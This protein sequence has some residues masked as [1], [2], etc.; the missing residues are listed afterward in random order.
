M[1]NES[2]FNLDEINKINSNGF[3]AL[4]VAIVNGYW[5]SVEILIKAGAV[6]NINGTDL[7]MTCLSKYYVNT[8]KL[9]VENG[10]SVAD[11]KLADLSSCMTA[12]TWLIDHSKYSYD[13]ETAIVEQLQ[14]VVKSKISTVD[15]VNIET[16]S[17]IFTYDTDKS[18]EIIKLLI[19]ENKIDIKKVFKSNEV[20]TTAL[21]TAAEKG[22]IKTV[23]LLLPYLDKSDLDWQNG[24]GTTAVWIS[25]CNRHADLLCELINAGADINIVNNKGD[26]ALIPA[27]QKGSVTVANILIE[28]GIDLNAHN[29]NRDNCVLI[30]CRNGQAEIL[31]MLLSRMDKSILEFYAEIDGFTPLLAATE[32]CKLECI[33]VCIKY[34]ADQNWRTLESNKVIQGAT[35]LHLACFYG[36]LDAVKL[37]IQSGSDIKAK[38]SYDGQ[39]C[40]HIA[41]NAGYSNVVGFLIHT[42]PSLI[43]IPDNFNKLPVHYATSTGR[44]DIINTYFKDRLAELMSSMLSKY[45]DQYG[46]IIDA[47]G[48]SNGVFSCKEVIN[49]NLGNGETLYTRA[50]MSGDTKLISKL[51]SLGA[52]ITIAD[53]YGIT[54]AFWKSVL[55]GSDVTDNTTADYVEKLNKFKNSNIQN[56]MLLLTSNIKKECSTNF[57][58]VLPLTSLETEMSCGFNTKCNPKTLNL[59]TKSNETSIL[60]FLDKLTKAKIFPDG[61]A[62]LSKL[63]FDAK[64]NMIKLIVSANEPLLQ[65][66]YQIALYL[67]TGNSTI[68]NQVCATLQSFDEKNIWIPFIVCLYKAVNS[69]P[70]YNFEV[71]R[72]VKTVFDPEQYKIGC[73]VQ[74]NCFS[75][76]TKDWKLTTYQIA[77][78]SGIIF[79]VKSKSARDISRYAHN[80][81]NGEVVFLPGS[82]FTVTAIYKADQITLAQANIR[83]QTFTAKETDIFKASQSKS[84]IIVELTE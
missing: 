69:A 77:E 64:I 59:I 43:D 57:S 41:I 82:S 49:K 55:Y 51:E 61:T 13:I 78:K 83:A 24:L 5:I 9:L 70:V 21:F 52:D 47:Y 60:T 23:Q 81:A 26:S 4:D 50:L 36:K 66:L 48:E 12:K 8:S 19:D 6:T 84:T 68:N 42:D 45:N 40:L 56:K 67:Y 74:W 22:A 46:N 15:T 16:I 2:E 44:E 33:K 65:P 11:K 3:T 27:C 38:T 32:L 71:Y 29:Q 73:N 63:L 54:P 17:K 25:S 80:P 30:C 10:I 58:T 28:S 79:I 39:T 14:D 7:L 72:A 1:L 35:A 62:C 53:D 31:D 75:T 76:C 37:L 20:E 18:L 34:G